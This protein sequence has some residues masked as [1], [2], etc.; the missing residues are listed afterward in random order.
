MSLESVT[1][2]LS[3]QELSKCES[4]VLQDNFILNWGIQIYILHLPLLP[5]CGYSVTSCLM[6]LLSQ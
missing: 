3:L 2:I 1:P 4:R 5:D 6:I